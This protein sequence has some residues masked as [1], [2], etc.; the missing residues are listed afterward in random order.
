MRG[1]PFEKCSERI[2]V[3]LPPSDA[4]RYGDGVAIFR[5][6]GGFRNITTVGQTISFMRPTTNTDVLIY[7]SVQ[8]LGKN[9]VF[10]EVVLTA[11]GAEALAAHATA[12]WALIP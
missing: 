2:V 6:F 4:D 8:K 10:G 7:A 12:T 11:S 3:C 1:K 5:A 9:I